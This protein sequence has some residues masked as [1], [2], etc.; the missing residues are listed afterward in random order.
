MTEWHEQIAAW[1]KSDPLKYDQNFNGILAQHAI[2]ELSRQTRGEDTI[3]TVGVGQ[4][5]MWTAQF[6]KFMHPRTF[7]SSSGLGTMGFGLPAALGAM[8]A[9]P[10][11]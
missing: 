4:H 2:D 9:I 11:N 1:K 3:I 7:L 8:A 6:Y 5:Q 10:T